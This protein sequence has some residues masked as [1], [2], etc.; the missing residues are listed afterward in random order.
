MFIETDFVLGTVV[1]HN[2]TR[3][4]D[5]T[6]SSS[7]FKL[8]TKTIRQ[9]ITLDCPVEERHSTVAA[10]M[11]GLEVTAV[12]AKGRWVKGRPPSGKSGWLAGTYGDGRGLLPSSRSRRMVYGGRHCGLPQRRPMSEPPEMLHLS[13]S[14]LPLDPHLLA[15]VLH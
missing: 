11:M 7:C 15:L 2:E 13:A 10:S 5:H 6:S 14:K 8:P 12:I 1:F 4:I 3:K 9:L